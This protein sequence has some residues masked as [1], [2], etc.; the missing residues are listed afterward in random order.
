[1][2]NFLTVVI[3]YFINI[4][5]PDNFLKSVDPVIREAEHFNS[6]F[7]FYWIRN[8]YNC[9]LIINS[10]KTGATIFSNCETF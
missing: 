4:D 6:D 9:E 8:D 10:T 2:E 7:N 3:L 5:N 1:M